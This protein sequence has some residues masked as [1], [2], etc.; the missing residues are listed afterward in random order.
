[1]SSV[2]KVSFVRFCICDV[3]FVT[4]SLAHQANGDA[5]FIRFCLIVVDP[6]NITVYFHV[7]VSPRP[8]W[9]LW[10]LC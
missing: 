3:A 4:N 1:M 5:V 8:W 6:A 2:G 9:W 7:F 10:W